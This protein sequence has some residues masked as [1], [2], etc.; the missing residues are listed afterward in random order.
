MSARTAERRDLLGGLREERG[1][2][3]MEGLLVLPLYLVLLGALF[4][5]GDLAMGHQTLMSA[6]RS[7]TWLAYDR[8]A[9]HGETGMGKM[10]ASFLGPRWKEHLRN[11]KVEE[12]GEGFRPRPGNRWQNGY[13]GKG[14]LQV[15]VPYWSKVA[16]AGQIAQSRGRMPSA[17]ELEFEDGYDL[18][19]AAGW[20]SYVIRRRPVKRGA[21]FKEEWV[22]FDRSADGESLAAYVMDNTVSEPWLLPGDFGR[23]ILLPPLVKWTAEY[24]REDD[25]VEWGQ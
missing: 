24:T 15:D 20:R 4:V 3:L 22:F 8:F 7:V 14:R 18:P 6:E 1:S 12:D 17:D 21:W 10:L 25:L 11:W 16:N 5:V 13:Q 19:G 2:V 9:D 23:H